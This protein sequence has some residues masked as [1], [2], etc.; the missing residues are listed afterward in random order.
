MPISWIAQE[1]ALTAASLT[2]RAQTISPNDNGQL[3]WDVFMPRANVDSV[4]LREILTTDWR[5][6]SDRREWNAG[7]RLIPVKTPDQKELE[8]I[9]IEAYF[10]IG[11]REIQELE[12][13][14]LGNEDVF[15]RIVRNQVPDRV[16]DLTLANYRRVEIDVFKA[17][18]LGQ[19]VAM[20]PVTGTSV[21]TSL[22]FSGSR[23]LTAG[24]AWNGA[25]N[26]YDE[27]LKFLEDSVDF[28]G[29]VQGAVMRL[30]TLKEIQKDAPNPFSNVTGIQITR[31]Q[32][33][34]RV[35]DDIGADF[36][37]YIIEN[38]LDVFTA[39]G[40]AVTR[41]KV[42]PAQRVAAVPAGGVVGSTVFAPVA[43]A[44]DLAR[45]VPQ[46]GIDVRGQTVYYTSENDG[47]ALKCQ[48]QVNAFPLPNEQL[49]YVI[50]AGV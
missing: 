4:K 45:S 47:K 2:V 18:A 50:N 15:R 35:A 9:P 22:G 5:P 36:R 30:A 37:F 21:T 14:T 6:V 13:R 34:Q 39:G 44:F 29:P 3:L 31:S 33:E 23:Y 17:W 28:V 40:T 38:S 20:N 48:A 11:E 46:A 25:V 41:T 42:W 12:E 10:R 43:R 49:M 1:Q 8:M 16:D 19:V 26:A 32:L 27:F 24:T 7:G